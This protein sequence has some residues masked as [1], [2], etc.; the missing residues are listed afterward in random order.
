MLQK[1]PKCQGPAKC[2]S[3]PGNDRIIRQ[4]HLLCIFQLTIYLHL[5]MFTPKRILKNYSAGG[6]AHLTNIEFALRGLGPRAVCTR[7]TGYIHDKTKVFNENLR[8]NYILLLKYCKRQCSLL[9]SNWATALTKFN[10]K[11]QNFK[12][13]LDLN[14]E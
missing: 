11:M 10:T 12:R 3:G 13:V 8:M 4:N 7:I 14:C 2:K 5:A 1:S 9:P 6:N